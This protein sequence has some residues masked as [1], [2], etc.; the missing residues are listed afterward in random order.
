MLAKS[1]KI[2]KN[3]KKVDF[4]G[5]RFYDDFLDGIQRKMVGITL[6]LRKLPGEDDKEFNKRRAR[7]AVKHIRILVYAETLIYTKN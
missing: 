4:W 1:P 5:G 3:V 6:G 7:E 2:P